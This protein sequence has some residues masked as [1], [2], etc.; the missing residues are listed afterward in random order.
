M[1]HPVVLAVTTLDVVSLFFLCRAAAG[2]VHIEA[3]WEPGSNGRSQIILERAF[4]TG[5]ISAGVVFGLAAFSTL[6]LL[7]GI[8]NVFPEIVPGAMCGTGVLQATKGEGGRAILFRLIALLLLYV[9]SVLESL[10]RSRPDCPM[11]R[12]NA[13]MLL[14]AS[15]FA[16]LGFLN[17]FWA[18]GSL[19]V[20]SP[21][22]CCTALY[23]RVSAGEGVLDAG[24]VSDRWWVF[25]FVALTLS[26]LSGG[27][28]GFAAGTQRFGKLSAASA[29][30]TL[31]WAPLAATALVRVFSA[32]YYE[33]LHHHCPWCLFL[34]EHGFAGFPLFFLWLLASFQ[35]FA[36]F[37]VYRAVRARPELQPL[38]IRKARRLLLWA[39]LLA[40][41]FAIVAVWPAL[42]W[43]LHFGVWMGMTPVPPP[44]RSW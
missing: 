3:D 21:V 41:L 37:A 35:G 10:N 16:F 36:G 11:A 29:V 5:A 26:M 40:G 42:S 19:D 34:P 39:G 8:T 18:F 31:L 13:R 2:A 15:P 7:L 1:A 12:L 14:L 38:G 28:G 20:Y 4:E 32:Y 43:R 9:W 44:L 25:S 33:V 27:L 23:D 6:I 22:S 24:K 30:T 17:T